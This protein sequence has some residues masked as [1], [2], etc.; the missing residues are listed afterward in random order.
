M[1]LPFMLCLLLFLVAAV[2]AGTFVDFPF[3]NRANKVWVPTDTSKALPL[4][5]ALHGCTQNPTDIAKGTNLNEISDKFG[6]IYVLY[7]EQPS[8][9]NMNKCWNW[10]E[11]AHQAFGAGEPLLLANMVKAVQAKYTIDT[12]RVYCLGMSAGAAMSVILGATY[13]DIFSA[14][15]VGSGIEYKA[16]TSVIS[17]NNAMLHGGPSPVTQGRLA[18]TA[19]GTR[20]AAL[21]VFVI[22]GTQD[23]TVYPV[24]GGQV[25]SQYATTLDLVINHGTARGTLTDKPTSTTTGT[26]PVTGGRAY[27]LHSYARTDDAHVLMKYLI[28]T[29]MGHAWSG[30]NPAGTYTDNK[31]PDASSMAVQFFTNFFRNSTAFDPAL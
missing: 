11:P 9:S 7:P 25:I 2:H 4:I 14:I 19:M 30:G 15:A 23:Y 17:A 8:S 26:A 5:V 27:T 12:A 3:Q 21:G 1:T 29:G 24:N 16:A 10:F 22:H 6:G 28:V 20:A 18:Y 31:G 13:P